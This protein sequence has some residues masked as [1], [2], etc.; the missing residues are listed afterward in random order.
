[1]FWI[2]STASLTS[3]TPALQNQK[4]L[5]FR[6]IPILPR[7][8]GC[9]SETFW[10]KFPHNELPSKPETRVDHEKLKSI[11]VEKSPLLLKSEITRAEKCIDY[12]RDGG[13]SFQI[14]NWALAV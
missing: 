4:S 9:G 13:P 14:K 3:T 12:L 8:G 5:K 6:E 2:F 10:E 11:L 1:M 7:Y